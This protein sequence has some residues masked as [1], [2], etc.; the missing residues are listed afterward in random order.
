MALKTQFSRRQFT[1]ITAATGM[2]AFIPTT[3]PVFAASQ[4]PILWT[5]VNF[6]QD[7]GTG[8]ELNCEAV[9]RI[10]PFLSPQFKEPEKSKF[11]TLK[12]PGKWGAA[13]GKSRQHK[14][15][16]MDD[17]H[18]DEFGEHFKADL[19]MIL[20]ITS[21]RKLATQYYPPPGGD[22]NFMVYE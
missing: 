10:F 11:L 18:A 3:T 4:T 5:G 9:D 16:W 19:A 1:A 13:I 14:L 15:V 17:E 21:D 8:K 22:V 7:C 2:G 6:I 12:L 20:G